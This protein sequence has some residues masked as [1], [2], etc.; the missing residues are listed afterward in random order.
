MMPFIRVIKME[1]NPA[2]APSRNAG[3]VA[4]EMTWESWLRSVTPCSIRVVSV[5][6]GLP[7]VS[8]RLTDSDHYQLTCP[9]AIPSA[10]RGGP[11]SSDVH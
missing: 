3:A 5:N 2:T 7:A 6:K 8:V 10:L 9:K 4:C 11:G 1:T